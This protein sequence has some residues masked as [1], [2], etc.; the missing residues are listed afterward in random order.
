MRT[1]VADIQVQRS[2]VKA[3]NTFTIKAT[4][5]AFDILSSG[6]YSDKIK[7]IVR[8]L[9]CNAYDSHVAAGKADTPI[10]VKLPTSLDYTFYVKDFGLGLSP[11]DLIRI[12]T[13]YFESTKTDSDDFIGQLGL[14]S[15]SPF[16]YAP[17]FNVE[18]RFEGM[19]QMYVCFKNE[20]GLPAITL[21]GEE[22]TDEPNGLTVSLSVKREDVSKFTDAAKKVFM[23]FNPQPNVVGMDDFSPYKLNHTIKGNGWMIREADYYAFMN[24]AYVVQGFVPYPI[25]VYQLREHGLSDAAGKLARSN[26]D[27]YVDIGKVEVAASREALSYDARTIQNLIELLEAA[28]VEM[29]ASFQDEFDKCTTKWEVAQLLGR[30]R[31]S[32]STEFR[33]IFTAMH[34][35]DPFKWNGVKVDGFVELDMSSIR[36]TTLRTMR[37]A[38][39]NK[40]KVDGIWT[41]ENGKKTI[42]Y[43]LSHQNIHIVVD[44]EAKGHAAVAEFVLNRNMANA[45]GVSPRVLLIAPTAKK[46]YSQ[47]EVN[48]L[49]K[50]M[51]NPPITYAS[52]L[53]VDRRRTTYSYQKRAPEQKMVWQGFPQLTSGYGGTSTKFS[54]LCWAT[55][56]IDLDDGGFYV[57][58]ER[59]AAVKDGF[60]IRSIDDIIAAAKGLGI[61]PA[62]VRI[63]GMNENDK[64]HIK[65]NT[66]WVNV[67]DYVK[68]QFVDLNQNNV[69]FNRCILAEIRGQLSN[70]VR[71]LFIDDWADQ[72]AQ[73]TE[74]PFTEFFD[75][76]EA[77]EKNSVDIN[78]QYVNRLASLL[79]IRTGVNA[80]AVA[81]YQEW[82]EVLKQYGML[83]L[84]NWNM[85]TDHNIQQVI[86][87]INAVTPKKP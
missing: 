48:N 68:Q 35:A 36:T 20:M 86:S 54:R 32:G 72:R 82:E 55:E 43:D 28:S 30:L 3:E 79:S 65:D 4:S 49:I 39:K 16:S 41:P 76:I 59:F 57:D 67:Y 60:L 53:N 81:L 17:T 14:G 83:P 78:V 69:L 33:E 31:T 12:Y 56:T 1:A 46:L 75:K 13:T 40:D 37:V 8:E 42:T 26:L 77:L 50:Q 29:R 87:Y 44:H 5:K 15:K 11:E 34:E 9:S 21:M 2:G 63:Y 71:D 58:V 7:A 47:A 66:D 45:A 62:G 61:L 23:Y 19:K 18:S 22:A 10:E 85:L 27:I 64:K 38:R 70:R 84:L 52:T 73:L 25:D 80:A 6:L 24:K 74:G 51:G